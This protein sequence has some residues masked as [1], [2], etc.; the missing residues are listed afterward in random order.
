MTA[1]FEPVLTL[2]IRDSGTREFV[3]WEEVRTW[4]Q[5]EL[6]VWESW[7]ALPTRPLDEW[8][9][10]CLTPLRN[11]SE[12]ANQYITGNESATHSNRI[13]EISGAFSSGPAVISDSTSGQRLLQYVNSRDFIKAAIY[14]GV[15]LNHKHFHLPNLAADPYQ[16]FIPLISVAAE[17]MVH[18]AVLNDVQSRNEMTFNQVLDAL[19]NSATQRLQSFD[20]AAAKLD[21]KI[22]RIRKATDQVWKI[23]RNAAEDATSTRVALEETYEQKLRLGAPASYWRD[24]ARSTKYASFLAIGTFVGLL[25]GLTAIGLCHG[26]SLKAFLSDKDGKIEL[27]AIALVAPVFIVVLGLFRIIGRSYML[28]QQHAMECRQRETMMSTFLSLTNDQSGKITDAE[29][30]IVLQALFRPSGLNAEV[31][32][33]PSNMFEVAAAA[34][35]GAKT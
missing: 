25:G 24:R 33:I 26:T 1:Q 31:E 3:S 11:L 12:L 27:A 35:K 15:F 34:F 29:R 28:N 21:S 10:E 17:Q 16:F 8:R 7:A 23:I 22:E 13:R 32:S 9:E 5:S 30:L 2:R 18:N 4:V 14:A 19:Q 6:R 20:R